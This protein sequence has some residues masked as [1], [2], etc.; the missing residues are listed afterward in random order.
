VAFEC[1][2][3]AH[4]FPLLLA[5]AKQRVCLRLACYSFALWTPCFSQHDVILFKDS[6]LF[7]RGSLILLWKRPSKEFGVE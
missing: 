1:C 7:S 3:S 2:M 4:Y 5:E 6:V